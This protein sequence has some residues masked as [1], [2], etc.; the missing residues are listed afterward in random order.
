MIF[1]KK[2]IKLGSYKQAIMISGNEKSD[3]VLLFLHGGPGTAHIGI[4]RAFQKEW[5]KRYVV[6]NWDQ[7]GAGL[8]YD[9][10][11][12]QQD[13]TIDRMIDYL[14]ELVQY[15]HKKFS[16]KRLILVAHSWGTILGS[17]FVNRFP[18]L[19]SKYVAISPVIDGEK[20]EELAYEYCYKCAVE[21]KD[22]KAIQ[23]LKR[24]GHPPYADLLGGSSVRANYGNKFGA[25][26]KSGTPA[27][28]YVPHMLKGKEYRLSDMVKW[29]QG[30][31]LSLTYLWSEVT[32]FRLEDHVKEIKV[33]SLFCLG[34]Y[35]YTAPTILA[36]D[37]LKK[38][39]K[40]V[41]IVTF[42]NSAHLCFIE[43]QQEFDKILFDFVEQE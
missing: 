43:E 35:D 27:K 20:G 11:I 41:N 19:V 33:P 23:K 26:I 29:L 25:M 1:K 32:H 7:L 9:K 36:Y 16:D 8:S 14:Y 6:I 21:R 31:T 24:I 34:K 17:L 3:S 18:Y 39:D 30:N 10:S 4:A 37:F 42:K 12:Q 13:M 38:F 5:E 40:N 28:I 22:K 15:I 2:F